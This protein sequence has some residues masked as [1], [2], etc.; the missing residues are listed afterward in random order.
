LSQDYDVEVEW[1]AF[2][3]HPEIP[4]Q[5]MQLPPQLRAGFGGMSER[6]QEMAQ[7]AGMP[8]VMPDLIPNS[9]RALEAAEY[10][11]AQGAH[12]PFHTVVFR[13]LYAEGQDIGRWEVLRAAAA[14]V[15][16]DPDAMQRET[17]AG[18]YRA[19]VDRQIAQARALGISGVPTYIFDDQYAVVGAQPYEVFQQAMGR[20]AQDAQ[21]DTV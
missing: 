5:G 15:G 16:M 8:M 17:E 20:L 1:R 3:L 13:Q 7:E 21:Q 2:E 14:E 6:V 9:R 4:P 10:A 11:R 18:S 19:V 12:K